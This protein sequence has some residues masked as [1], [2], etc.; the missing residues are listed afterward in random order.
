MKIEVK[1]P[2]VRQLKIRLT[3][4]AQEVAPGQ[5]ISVA[6]GQHGVKTNEFIKQFNDITKKYP[7]GFL[8][9][10]EITVNIDGSFK[11]FLKGVSIPFLLKLFIN[12]SSKTIK[13]QD[14]LYILFLIR[15][16]RQDLF[17]I[18]DLSI[19]KFLK[20]SLSCKNI[21]IIE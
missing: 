1:T 19:L 6:L 7:K 5:V 21:Q 14:L 3:L 15:K 10:S 2:P 12:E 16:F 20:G 9:S 17:F 13:F 18:K 11:I 8:I 4:P